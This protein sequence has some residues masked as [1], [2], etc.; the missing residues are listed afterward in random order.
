MPVRPIVA[1]LCCC[2]A[3][4]LFGSL[5][6][7]AAAADSTVSNPS[8]SA[9]VYS[10]TAPDGETY[11]ALSLKAEDLPASEQQPR[12]HVVLMDTSASQV[13]AHRRQALSVL[14]A[15]VKALPAADRVSL[16]AVDVKAA[17]LSDGFVAADSPELQAA[18]TTLSRR[19]PAGATDLHAAVTAGLQQ[20]DGAISGSILYIGDGM[21]I[22]GLV[23]PA[24]LQQLATDLQ[25]RQIPVHSYA[26]GPRTDLQLLGI[27]GQQTGGFVLVDQADA[28]RDEP[29]VVAGRLAEAVAAPV[30]YPSSLQT[31]ATGELLPRT[32][33]PLRADRETIYLGKGKIGGTV[34]VSGTFGGQDTSLQWAISAD[35]AQPGQAFLAAMWNQAERDA[36]L[37]VALAGD[38]LLMAAHDAFDR[39]VEQMVEAGEASLAAREFETVEQIALAVN[40]VDPGNIRAK[41]LLGAANKVQARTV[42][43]V[44][45]QDQPAPERLLDQFAPGRDD[46]LEERVGPPPQTPDV[47]RDIQERVRLRT[48]Q[49]QL[50]VTRTMEEARRI[51]GEEPEAALT[52]LKRTLDIVRA[53]TDVLPDVQAQL[54]RR[55]TGLIV[56]IGNERERRELVRI[57]ARRRLALIDAEQRIIAQIVQEEE[58]L[59]NLI[60]KVRGLIAEGIHGRDPA[61]EEAVVVADAA[62]N[63]RPGEG[64]ASAARFTSEAILQ[65]NRAF[66]MRALRANQFLETLHQVELSHVPFPDEP[67]ILW[68]SAEVWQQLTE[69]RRKWADV[70]LRHDSPAEARIRAELDNTTNVDFFDTPLKDAMEYLADLHGIV[71]ILDDPALQDEGI[72]TDVP[73]TQSLS[74]IS[75]RSALRIILQQ[76]QLTYIIE[77]EVMKITTELAAEDETRMQTRIYPVGDLVLTPDAL[78]MM[79][80]M[81][82]MM[83][84]MGGM[85]GGMMGGMGGMGGMGMG[86]MG[87]MGMGGMGGGMGMGGMGGGMGMGMFSIA[88][89]DVPKPQPAKAKQPNGPKQPRPA[90][91]RPVGDPEVQQILD[92]ILGDRTSS[93]PISTG[94]AFAQ[95]NDVLPRNKPFRFDNEAIEAYK[96]KRDGSR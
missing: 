67:P 94:Q 62:V 80:M 93:L 40:R 72:Q 13:G 54:I 42:A 26:V 92:D 29:A 53:Q 35:R 69:R 47:I 3:L 89:E 84:G 96:K 10:Y 75:L 7:F 51:A 23:Q 12:N 36:G 68:P 45:A 9:G 14:D 57:E 60:E 48:E 22:A 21:S 73:I 70:D 17:P 82:M 58:R 59:E 6:S 16:L 50:E 95:V 28:E 83:G 19:V 37:S 33:L 20:F 27:L 90:K 24:A 76:H 34:S 87:G 11:F 4:V 71:I 18:L 65:L 2:P 77:D 64:T 81:G 46:D 39:H 63:L 61:Y 38:S 1:V 44:D 85:G 86:G 31:D 79:A 30:F 49:L 91:N 74:G 88:P 66:R 55:L 32:A 78:R 25:T 5:A 8:S 56:D 15:F 52:G 41:A 43:Q